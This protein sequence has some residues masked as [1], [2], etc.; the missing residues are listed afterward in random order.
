[1]SKASEYKVVDQEILLGFYKNLLWDRI[2]PHIP[3]R[4]TPNSITVAGQVMCIIA[5][6]I[7]Y[8]ATLTTYWLLPLSSLFLL[9][10]LTADNLD[11]PHARRTGQSSPSASSSTTGSTGWPRVRC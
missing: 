9:G 6:L 2:L 10:Y 11:G 4:I 5:V 7:A 3:A 8:W 1:M